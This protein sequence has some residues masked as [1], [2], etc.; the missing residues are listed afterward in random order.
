MAAAAAAQTDAQIEGYVR[1]HAETIY[2]PV[3][4]CLAE[5]ASELIRRALRTS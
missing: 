5:K 4:T 2:H 3:G 1:Q